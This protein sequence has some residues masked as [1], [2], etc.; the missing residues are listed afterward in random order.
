MIWH[1][2]KIILR[3]V[4]NRNLVLY[5]IQTPK[6]ELIEHLITIM[7]HPFLY[8]KTKNVP[9][10]ITF[11]V[12]VALYEAVLKTKHKSSNI[13]EVGAYKGLSTIYLTEAASRVNKKVSHL[14]G[15]LDC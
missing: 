14:I 11:E 8:F 5:V 13:I 15:F 6:R 12:G 10:L 1:N 3:L 9:G 2:F 4:F 7:K